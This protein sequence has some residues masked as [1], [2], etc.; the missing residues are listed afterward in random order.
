LQYLYAT[1]TGLNG[2]TLPSNGVLSEL[3]L[4]ETIKSLTLIN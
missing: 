3:R 1:G 2:I 4:P